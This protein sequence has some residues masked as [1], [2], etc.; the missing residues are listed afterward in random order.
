MLRNEDIKELVILDNKNSKNDNKRLIANFIMKNGKTI[1]RKFGY[2]K[3]KS[4]YS[5]GASEEKK[6]AYIKRHSVNEDFDNL[7]T[8]GSLSKI[9]LWSFRTNNEIEKFYNRKYKIPKVKVNF[10]RRIL[11]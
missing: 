9:V 5:D 10:K 3:A 4:T 2:S 1:K 8:A 6:N 7:F 11:S